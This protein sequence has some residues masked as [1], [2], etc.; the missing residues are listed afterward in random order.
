MDGALEALLTETVSIKPKTGLDASGYG[1][2]AY[3][4]AVTSKSRVTGSSRILK[5]PEG[6]E[7]HAT[8]EVVVPPATVVN[9][10]DLVT[11]AGVDWP[12]V[13][14]ETPRD[15]TGDVHHKRILTGR[16]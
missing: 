14:V 8:H 7:I 2:P 6:Q 15:E 4:T 12:V 11:I 13:A 10:E 5:L 9:V 16:A 1:G 3:G